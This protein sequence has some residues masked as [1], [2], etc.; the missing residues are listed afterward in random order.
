M[1]T[2]SK[3]F[4]AGIS[5][6]KIGGLK[7]TPTKQLIETALDNI[8]QDRAAVSIAATIYRL[9]AEKILTDLAH[10]VETCAIMSLMTTS[11]VAQKYGVTTGL[12]RKKAIDLRKAGHPIG[13]ALSGGHW[14]FTPEEAERLKPGRTG[15]PKK[16]L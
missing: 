12:I 13:Q 4:S 1:T 8:F 7:L 16:L 10:E 14:L 3:Q 5:S 9:R 15:R 11:G 6:A 2:I